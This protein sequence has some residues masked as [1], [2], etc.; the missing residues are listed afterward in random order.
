MTKSPTRELVP[1]QSERP[2]PCHRNAYDYDGEYEFAIARHWIAPE[3]TP[4]PGKA[5]LP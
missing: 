3:A 5:R 1:Q 4:L 2:Q